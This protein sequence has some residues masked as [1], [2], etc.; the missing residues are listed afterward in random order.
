MTRRFLGT[1]KGTQGLRFFCCAGLLAC[2][3]GHVL[4]DQIQMQNG[5]RYSGRVLSLSSNT[6]VL[7]SEVLGIVRLPRAKVALLTLGTNT[8]AALAQRTG[9]T[10]RASVTPATTATNTNSDFASLVAQLGSNSN[11]MRQVQ[12]QLLA[13]AGPEATDKFNQLFG[14]LISGRLSLQDLRK[15]AQS[16]ADQ[17]RAMRSDLGP[18]AS[19]IEGYLA[20]L[21]SFLKESAAEAAS[22]NT[23]KPSSSAKPKQQP[24]EE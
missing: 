12:G 17:V 14:G 16:A 13:G 23:A 3:S 4:A 10:N 1:L 24:D 7:Q 9:Q 20:V 6:V 15:E 11:L 8:P 22:T 19:V 21:D 2:L 18:E 5:D